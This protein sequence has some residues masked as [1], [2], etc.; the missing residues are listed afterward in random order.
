[1]KEFLEVVSK[2]F[3]FRTAH[4]ELV[5]FWY[6]ELG[7]MNKVLH[8]WK[9]GTVSIHPFAPLCSL[10]VP[11]LLGKKV[12]GMLTCLFFVALIVRRCPQNIA[13]VLTSDRNT[14]ELVRTTL[15]CWDE[16]VTDGLEHQS[17]FKTGLIE[18]LRQSVS[19]TVNIFN[20]GS[21]PQMS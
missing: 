19:F 7:A 4:S 15:T 1:M 5:G 18:E 10:C 16:K 6:S 12:R 17:L 20:L 8:I 13:P 9:Y 2:Y 21:V 11:C 3:H 14:S